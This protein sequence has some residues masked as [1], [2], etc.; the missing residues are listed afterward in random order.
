M[1]DFAKAPARTADYVEFSEGLEHIDPDEEELI[2]KIVEALHRNNVRAF[3]KHQHA[4]RDAHSKS[5]GVLGGELTVYPDL[6]EPLRQ[7]LFAAPATYPVIARLS[8]TAGAIRSDQVHGVRGIA[9]K[10]LGVAGPRLR[11]DGHTSH[12]FIMVNS[13]FFPF[14]D[15]R[16]YAEKM[17][18]AA[19][20]ARTPD[21][22]LRVSGA[23]FRGINRI[24]R[25]IGRPLRGPAAL[26][27]RPNNNLLGETYHSASPLRYGRYVAKIS[28]WPH[29]ESV[30]QLT[31][32]PIADDGGHE[33]HTEL[34][35][36]FFANNSAEYEVRAQLCTDPAVMSID[37]ATKDWPEEL[38]PHLRVAKITFPKQDAC[39]PARR[40]FGDD[41]LSFNSWNG[42]AAHR[43][44]GGINRLK[45]RA[46]AASSEYRHKMN[47]VEQSEPTDISELPGWFPDQ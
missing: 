47:N 9:I 42:L 11:P 33:A 27:A 23:A 20:L 21:T 29:S 46:Y 8:T 25:P 6:E 7:G 31:D 2:T 40:V 26:F 44:L 24:G 39:S 15:V 1:T 4:I 14:A 5:H 41:R 37:D 13:S 18:F 45:L 16:A 30:K 34:V 17:G 19:L 32:E 43:P 36:D 3:E 28:V 12:D 22:A 35:R 38:S 10:V